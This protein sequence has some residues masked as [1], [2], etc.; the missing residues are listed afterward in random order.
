MAKRDIALKTWLKNKER[1][2]DFF[3]GALFNGEQIVDS[4]DLEEMDSESN[5]IDRDKNASTTY[6]KRHRDVVMRWRGGVNLAILAIENQANVCYA[7]PARSMFYDALSYDEQMKEIHRIK[8]KNNSN[9]KGNYI[10]SFGINDRICPAVTVVF[11]HGDVPWKDNIELYDMFQGRETEFFEN[12]LKKYV[13][14]YKLNIVDVSNIEDIKRFKSDLQIV[15]GML[16]C[17]NNKVEMKDY[18]NSNRKQLERVDIDTVETISALLNMNQLDKYIPKAKKGEKI[19][20]CKAM[21]DWCEENKEIGRA[22]GIKEGI[23][24]GR[25]EG[26]VEGIRSIVVNMIRKG[27]ST[28]DICDLAQC[29]TVYVEELRESIV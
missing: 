10:S 28:E 23:K 21:Q 19:D 9:L 25:V 20:M 7:M 3:N 2:A 18:V 27:L 24:E 22:E 12:I 11:Y 6:I 26:R 5:K 17:K 1:F 16:K 4:K 29:E 15:L 13:P 14:N 8:R